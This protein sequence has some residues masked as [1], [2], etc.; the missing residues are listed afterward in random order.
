MRFRRQVPIGIWIVDFACFD[1]ALAIEVDGPSHDFADE[2]TRSD[3]IE[4]AGFSLLR[5][6]NKDV[7]SRLGEVV[8]T[9]EVAIAARRA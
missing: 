4:D 7:A 3:A 1:P 8:G 2:S 9:I 6:T 5:F